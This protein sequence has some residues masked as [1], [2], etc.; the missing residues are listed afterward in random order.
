MRA[1]DSDVVATRIPTS[2]I[3][4]ATALHPHAAAKLTL[5]QSAGNRAVTSLVQRDQ[6]EH[7]TGER[8][9]S[10]LRSGGSPLEPAFRARAES[11]LGANLTHV[12]V[13][14][15]G[16]A[17][18]S[19]RAVQSHAYTSGSHIVFGRGMYD[20][21]SGA[22]QRRIAHEL[23]HVV[24]QQRGPVAGTVTPGG[25]SISEPSDRFEREAARS[26]EAFVALQRNAGN[27]AI[28]TLR[29]CEDEQAGTRP[30]N[31]ATPTVLQRHTVVNS[32]DFRL[33]ARRRTLGG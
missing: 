13:H 24:Q 15:D 4:T 2:T 18:Q 17:A 14:T 9:S 31:S 25:L 6:D 5:Q 12:R 8:V 19:A 26:G 23:T 27:R 7:V 3:R 33:G 21:T 10:V 16:A 30:G 20:T 1:R 22:G 11:F 29:P 28:G 32:G